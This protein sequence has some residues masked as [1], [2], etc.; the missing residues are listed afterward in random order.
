MTGNMGM[1][2]TAGIFF[3][4]VLLIEGTYLVF[5]ALRNSEK[6]KIRNRLRTLSSAT[7]GFANEGTDITR[8]TLASD[9]PRL[10]RMLLH[11]SL[12]NRMIRLLEQ[13]GVQRTLGFYM[14]R[15]VL[16]GFAGLLVGS[17][18][19]RNSLFPIPWTVFLGSIPF[20]L[21][22]LRKKRR[23]LKF[24][25]QLPE[26]MDLIARSLKAGHPFSGGLKMVAD[27]FDDPVGVEFE[28]VSREINFGVSVPDALK[29]LSNRVDSRD[30]RF[31]IIS[32]IIQRESGGNLPE[33]LEKIAYLIRERFKLQ[34]RIRILS[35]E[36]R[37]SA[38]ILVG[39]PFFLAFALWCINP[40]YF[41]P[42]MTDR[43]G[44]AMVIIALLL[45]IAGIFTIK[46]MI[47]IKV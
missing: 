20:L 12:G 16:L 30:L 10:N 41:R 2:I 28:K 8:K 44:N 11:F 29:N 18:V 14:L 34:G 33:I 13:A 43:I 23:M 17:L 37:L 6:K 40:D 21:I 35:A 32:A 4:V 9:V 46:K 22:Y 47:E 27:E 25:R 19:M 26:A 39:I 7:E 3:V 42:L 15:S 24:Q 45:M 5:R 31:F 36:G 1:L 38:I